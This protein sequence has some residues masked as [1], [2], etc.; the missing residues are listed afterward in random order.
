MSQWLFSTQ[1]DLITWHSWKECRNALA[2]PRDVEKHHLPGYCF[3][4]G[5]FQGEFATKSS[6][7]H[8]ASSKLQEVVYD[9]ASQLKNHGSNLQDKYI[10]ILL[11]IYIYILYTFPSCCRRWHFLN[12]PSFESRWWRWTV[13]GEMLIP[14]QAIALAFSAWWSCDASSKMLPRNAWVDNACAVLLQSCVYFILCY[15]CF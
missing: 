14:I 4:L 3:C 2:D 8:E 9:Q 6:M 13:A 10:Y 5:G 7:V 12:F 11:Y 15:S 1:R